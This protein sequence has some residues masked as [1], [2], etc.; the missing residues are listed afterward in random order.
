MPSIS[1]GDLNPELYEKPR[2]FAC[3]KVMKNNGYLAG[4]KDDQ[5]VIVGSECLR[6]IRK[7]GWRGGITII[8][9]IL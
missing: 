4:C 1:N 2:C 9:I 7:A 8:K 5:T 6:H 3:D